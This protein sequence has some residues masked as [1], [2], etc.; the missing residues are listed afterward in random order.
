MGEYFVTCDLN[1]KQ[2]LSGDHM[3]DNNQFANVQRIFT[4][5]WN[6]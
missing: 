1:A 3:I 5:C 4:F 2:L 6:N